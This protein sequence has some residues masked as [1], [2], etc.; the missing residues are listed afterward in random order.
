MLLQIY[1][2]ALVAGLRRRAD[3]QHL[4]ADRRRAYSVG[5]RGCGSRRPAWRNL[6][7]NTL[8]VQFN[9]RM[10]AY[11]LWL[12]A[13]LARDRCHAHAARR[14]SLNGALA[15]ACAVT[16]QAGIGIVTLLHQ[17]PLPL[18]AA[19]PGHRRSWC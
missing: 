9:H 2:G 5:R 6:F 4:A 15:L 18:G 3:L 1:L 8:T 11:A 7:E 14:P 17:A 16:M 13:V 12:A 19:A 10:V